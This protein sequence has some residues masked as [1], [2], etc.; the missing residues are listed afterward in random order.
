MCPAAPSS[1]SP[2][3]EHLRELGASLEQWR[4]HGTAAFP[5]SDP[6]RSDVLEQQLLYERW[7]K[8][9]Q[10]LLRREAIP[11]L[12]GVDPEAWPR[13]NEDPAVAAAEARLWQWM[14]EGD[15]D[16]RPHLA[17]PA[18]ESEQWQVAPAAA[19]NWWRAAGMRVPETLEN[20]LQFILRVVKTPEAAPAA[21]AAP[22]PR[23][24][25][26]VLGAALAVLSKWPDR[27]RDEHGFADG[28]LMLNVIRQHAAA[29]FDGPELPMDGD[30]AY[31]LIERWLQ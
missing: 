17:N 25:E 9:E 26:Q 20:L 15:G 12:F 2:T 19:V 6:G 18:V 13:A 27:C 24:A 29:W 31:A 5:E 23:A 7:L 4:L 1:A 21:D 28:A 22:A 16:A 10:W 8:R 14:N 30:E 11:L 3:R